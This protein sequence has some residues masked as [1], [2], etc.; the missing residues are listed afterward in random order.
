MGG[1]EKRSGI[2]H[3]NAQAS[4]RAIT[5]NF[6]CAIP[7]EHSGSNYDDVE[8]RTAI[9]DCLVPC[10]AHKSREHIES[11]RGTLNIGGRLNGLPRIL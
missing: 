1:N 9:V 11:E 4:T 5:K 6:L 10:A 8:R 2:Q 7:A 3:E